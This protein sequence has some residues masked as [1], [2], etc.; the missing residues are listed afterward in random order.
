MTR[1]KPLVLLAL[2]SCTMLWGAPGGIG[3]VRT[4]LSESSWSQERQELDKAK[5]NKRPYH[6]TGRSLVYDHEILLKTPYARAAAYV[7][8]NHKRLAELTF[9][10][11]NK[12]FNGPE[13]TIELN[14]RSLSRDKSEAVSVVLKT[15]KGTV[16]P[17]TDQLIYSILR[18]IG[19][20]G[21]QYYVVERVFKFDLA[22]L[23]GAK[24]LSVTI[25]EYDGNTVTLPV[26]LDRLR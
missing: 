13:L 7:Q 22:A 6:L 3:S 18:E 24:S 2:L 20:Y 21:Q 5:V 8:E 23:E 26:D 19:Y 15:E 16:Q 9:E 25:I 12:A 11:V 10:E 14:T 4:T 17:V 1:G